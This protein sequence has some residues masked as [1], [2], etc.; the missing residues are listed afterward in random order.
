MYAVADDVWRVTY[1]IV[2]ASGLNLLSQ[3]EPLFHLGCA[4]SVFA[5]GI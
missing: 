3:A 4:D 1:V 5:L 2:F